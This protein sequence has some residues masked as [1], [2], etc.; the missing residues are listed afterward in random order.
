MKHKLRAA[1]IAVIEIGGTSVKIGFAVDNEPFTETRTFPTVTIRTAEPVKALAVLTRTVCDELGLWPM[2]VVATVPGFIDRSFDR[3]LHAANVPELNGR[4][5]ASELSQALGLP[6]RLERDVVLQLLGEC[7]AG[8]A[9]GE[10]HV[11]G[12]YLGTGIGAA[13]RGESRIF[14]GGGWALEIGHMPV[15]G[16]GETLPGLLPDRLEVY[17]SGRKLEALGNQYAIPVSAIFSASHG[18][19]ELQTKLMNLVRDQAFAIAGAIAMFSP[20]V[21]VLGGGILE[22][23]DYPRDRLKR[24]IV[25]HLPL[26][27]EVLPLDLRWAALGWR[28]AIYGALEIATETK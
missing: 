1:A 2:R 25:G 6:V 5:M 22:M 14:R 26:P 19:A 10:S 24:E 11:L 8:A 3:V 18:I 27:S 16:R 9:I 12:V 4:R 28:A 23:V 20:Q 21:V 17:A 15:H 13:Y 7:R